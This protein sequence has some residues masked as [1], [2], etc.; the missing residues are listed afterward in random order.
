MRVPA[1][2][3]AWPTVHLATGSKA[4]KLFD[5]GSPGAGVHGEGVDLDEFAGRLHLETLRKVLGM[6]FGAVDGITTPA[7][8]IV[9]DS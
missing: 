8:E 7:G 3:Q 2:R 5:D 6:E 1:Q 9:S 4:F